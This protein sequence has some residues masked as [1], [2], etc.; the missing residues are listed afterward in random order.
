MSNPNYY[1]QKQ[2]GWFRYGDPTPVPKNIVGVLP[3]I[4][5]NIIEAAGGIITN[6]LTVNGPSTTC[7]D[8]VVNGTNVVN[9]N[10]NYKNNLIVT[11]D[12][13]I[14]G[15][16][17]AFT[18]VGNIM[19]YAGTTA[20]TG[21]LLCDGSSYLVATYPDLFA[22]IGY[23]Y[24]GAGPNFNVPNLSGRV[25]ISA[26]VGAGRLTAN[27]NI[28]NTAGT[29]LVT[30]APN[31][32]G[33]H[34]HGAIIG[35]PGTHTHTVTGTGTSTTDGVHSMT[36]NGE[37]SPHYHTIGYYRPNALNASVAL[38]SVSTLPVISGY[39]TPYPRIFPPPP[40]IPTTSGVTSFTPISA[41]T[42]YP[43]I[44]GAHTHTFT[45]NALITGGGTH[46]H[47]FVGAAVG[48]DGSHNNLQPYLVTNFIIKYEV[49]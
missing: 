13:Y 15:V 6:T 38:G 23:T 8:K 2:R 1:G 14:N 26:D 32:S 31:E 33:Y 27:N 7:G 45:N 16:A 3:K 34:T 10:G 40:V 21:W 37:W 43:D 18:P 46:S 11:G 20:P 24:G 30:L 5:N 19:E 17:L 44:S 39:I 12:V 28:G 35:I 49:S 36:F 25:P 48:G 41:G 4:F 29:E 9:G 42:G 22:I 47:T